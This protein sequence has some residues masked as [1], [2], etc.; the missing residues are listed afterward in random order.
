MDWQ[1]SDKL[2]K[3]HFSPLVWRYSLARAHTR[4]HFALCKRSEVTS[5]AQKVERLFRKQKDPV[6]IRRRP[7]YQATK[8]TSFHSRRANLPLG[9]TMDYTQFL[10]R[11]DERP[12]LPCFGGRS[13]CDDAQTYRLKESLAPGWYVF[14]KSGRFLVPEGSVE[15]QLESWKLPRVTGYLVGGR[16]LGN[17]FQARLFGLSAEQE[18][19]KFSPISARKWFDGHLLFA[20]VEFETEVEPQVRDAFEEDRSIEAVRGVTPALAQAFVLESTQRA[21]AREAERRKLEEAQLQQRAAELAR[22]Q[23]TLEG[24]ISVALSHT[25]AAL[26]SWRR[27]GQDQAVVR[28]RLAGQRFEC[29]INT[30][31]LR[32]VDAGICLS[33]ADD[34]LNLSSLPSA[35]REAVETGRLHVFRQV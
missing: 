28:Y 27:Q 8:N 32:I 21:L 29:V 10:Q 6:R 26:I 22:W 4:H 12:K 18:P 19:P 13:V 7:A 15:P 17:D 20:G 3:Q 9:I 34:R 2:Q 31:T 25:G 23:E 33:G 14:R 30:G 5:I 16:L 24:R 35:V 1:Q 11:E